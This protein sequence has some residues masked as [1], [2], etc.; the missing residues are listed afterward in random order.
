[1][2]IDIN[3]KLDL[4]NVRENNFFKWYYETSPD[5]KETLLLSYYV[6]TS[7]ISNYYHDFYNNNSDS[8]IQTTVQNQYDALQKKFNSDLINIKSEKD[9]QILD[10]KQENNQQLLEA[11]NKYRE[12][13]SIKENSISS[14]ERLNRDLKFENQYSEAQ[15]DKWKS[16]IENTLILNFEKTNFDRFLIWEKEKITKDSLISHQKHNILQ[17][18]KLLNDKSNE[19]SLISNEKNREENQNLKNQIEILKNSNIFKGNLGEFELTNYLQSIF[20]TLTVKNCSKTAHS[21]DVHLLDNDNNIIAF[22]SKWKQNIE[23]SDISKFNCD[24]ESLIKMEMKV[25]GGVFV[26]FCTTNIPNKGKL[27]FE[28]GPENLPIC[29]VGYSSLNEFKAQFHNIILLFRSFCQIYKEIDFTSD[30]NDYVDELNYLFNL[31]IKNKTRI[32]D[33]RT[34]SLQKIN[35]FVTDIENENRNMY[36]RIE[37]VLKKHSALKIK[38]SLSCCTFCFEPFTNKKQLDKH[39]KN[40]R[41]S[42]QFQQTLINLK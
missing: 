9:K 12:I 27:L 31:L 2:S 41:G 20:D 4:D 35:K 40:C 21:C 18:E 13:I 1:M 30:S 6:I 11:E 3:I 15:R 26:S 5:P 7:G 29:Y 14:L 32:E 8:F 23:K 16:D 33:F 39:Q 24:L 17:L 22:E 36:N 28:L 25:I 38:D 42:E 10:L 19:I 34:N 37:K